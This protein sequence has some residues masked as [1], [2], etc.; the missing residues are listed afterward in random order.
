MTDDQ[1]E[2]MRIVYRRGGG[3]HFRTLQRLCRLE[4]KT[5]SSPVLQ[6]KRIAF[7]L[8]DEFMPPPTEPAQT[9]AGD[10]AILKQILPFTL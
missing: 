2:T 4:Y 10:A 8:R 9:G 5:P 7:C 3:V 6:C 1:T